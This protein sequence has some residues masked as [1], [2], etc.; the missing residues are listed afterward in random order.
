MDSVVVLVVV[1]ALL[2]GGGA[3][4]KLARSLGSAKNEFEKGL[5]E[6]KDTASNPAPSG[7]GFD[8]ENNVSLPPRGVAYSPNSKV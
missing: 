6:G 3:I 2:F 8:A 7:A 1:L 5:Q 4:P